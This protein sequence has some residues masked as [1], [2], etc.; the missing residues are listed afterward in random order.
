MVVSALTAAFDVLMA[1]GGPRQSVK[2]I[3]GDGAL[4]MARLS[5]KQP[6]GLK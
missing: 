6:G 3:S 1:D 2:N 5:Y 4:E